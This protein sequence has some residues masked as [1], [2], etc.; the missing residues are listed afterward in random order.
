ML[1]PGTWQEPRLLWSPLQVRP[2]LPH[3]PTDRCARPCFSRCLW[4]WLTGALPGALHAGVHLGHGL[5]DLQH[6]DHELQGKACVCVPSWSQGR[7]RS[8]RQHLGPHV[9][10]EAC[11][12]AEK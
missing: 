5:E 9:D 7:S 1:Y 6:S 11:V 2:R 12:V 4:V 3:S 8:Q 10:Q